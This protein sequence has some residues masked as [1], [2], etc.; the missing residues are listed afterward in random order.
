M[1]FSNGTGPGTVAVVLPGGG[2]RGAYEIGALSVLLPELEARGERVS[3]ICGTSVGAINAALM[4]SLAHLPPSEQ[5]ALALERWRTLRRSDV[6]SSFVSPRLPLNVA[7]LIGDAL[8]IPKI[9][10]GSLLD[11]GPL[12]RYL[13]RNLDWDALHRNVEDGVVEAVC[14]VATQ[15][16]TG[17]PLA[18]V[19]A[20]GDPPG[21]GGLDYVPVRL[22]GEHVRASAAIPLVFP[23]VEVS[24]PAAAAGYYTDGA[25]RLNSPI[26]PAVELGASRVIV[27]GF[28][29]LGGA[30]PKPRTVPPHLVDVAANVL[31]RLLVDQVAHDMHRLV[32]IN[33]FFVEDHTAGTMP[34][35]RAY[36]AARGR[37]PYRRISYAL[38][39]PRRRTE[40][41]QLA[42]RVFERRYGGLSGLLHPDQLLLG[43]LLRGR[44]DAGG[45]LLSVLLFEREYIDALIDAGRRD[46]KRWL[47]RHP[48]LWCSNGAHD[49]NIDPARAAGEHEAA[50]LEE[51][52]RLRRG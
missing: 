41:G 51:W 4:A 13:E 21:E 29:P 36:R 32:A 40:L 34:A 9:N 2:A 43:R 28:T 26:R 52:R 24:E 48:G 11:P 47:R 5:V 6:L 20:S 35:A 14:V 33:S 7:R 27:I 31:D 10:R 42:E 39:T 49:F 30:S 19:E 12:R 38:I 3:L 45:D 1:A 15:L 8:S 17:R 46:A 18:F 22:T 50:S 23:A 37:R 44:T 16:A 25:T